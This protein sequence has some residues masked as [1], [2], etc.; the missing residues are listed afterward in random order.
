MNGH[1]RHAISSGWPVRVERSW[2]A[3]PA[4]IGENERVLV[5]TFKLCLT[6]CLSGRYFV[7]DV[8]KFITKD[9]IRSHYL[10]RAMRLLCG[11]LSSARRVAQHNRCLSILSHNTDTCIS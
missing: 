7:S 9:E 11:Y 6:R 8:L 1:V 10:T 5:G 4:R 2:L 3:S